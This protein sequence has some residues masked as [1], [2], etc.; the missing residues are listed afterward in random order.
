MTSEASVQFENQLVANRD[1]IVEPA[2]PEDM[3]S[4]HD[5]VGSVI[6]GGPAQ[7]ERLVP[8]SRTIIQSGQAVE[9][10]VNHAFGGERWSERSEVWSR[11]C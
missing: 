1:V 11:L 5:R 7:R 3:R 8:V 4:S 9:V 10:E 2:I 6:S